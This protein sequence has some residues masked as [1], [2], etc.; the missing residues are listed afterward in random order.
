MVITSNS[1]PGDD[2]W[3]RPQKTY[4][5]T[6]QE[7]PKA[8]YVWKM[9]DDLGPGEAFVYPQGRYRYHGEIANGL[10]VLEWEANDQG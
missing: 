8:G 1:V 7:G 4:R 9:F 5:F 6:T 2:F 3:S 10:K